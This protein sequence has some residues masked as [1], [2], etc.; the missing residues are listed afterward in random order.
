VVGWFET[1]EDTDWLPSVGWWRGKKS[2]NG[3][4]GDGG[5]N[6]TR[7]SVLQKKHGRARG[8]VVFNKKKKGAE[9]GGGGKNGLGLKTAGDAGEKCLKGLTISAKKS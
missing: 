5:K 4:F 1:E 9:G 2:K 8:K 6:K 3:W 7:N